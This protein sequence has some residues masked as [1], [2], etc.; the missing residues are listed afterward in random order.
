MNLHFGLCTA[1]FSAGLLSF[2]SPCILPLLPLYFGYFSSEGE[3]SRSALA[4]RVKKTLAF[5]AGVS[6]VFFIMGVGAGLA[7]AVFQSRF[8]VLFCGAAIV[9]MGIHQTGLV[10]I[11]VLNRTR[12]FSSPVV[13]GRGLLG[14]FA[15]GFFFSFGWTPC[16]GP[17]LAMVLGISLQQGD[18]FSGGLLLLFYVAGF[19]IPFLLLAVG[20]QVLLKKLRGL[21]PYLDRI[22]IA[23]GVLVVAMGIWMIA[24]QIQAP[25]QRQVEGNT[26][27]GA[28]VQPSDWAGKPV[29][30]KFWATWCPLCLAGLD[31]FSELAGASAG[32]DDVVIYSVVAPGRHNEMD[33]K[34]FSEWA[35]GQHLSFPVLFDDDGALGRKYGI[36]AYPTSVFLDADQQ[37]AAVHI[38]HMNNDEIQ[39]KL[40]EL[41]KNREVPE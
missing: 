1:V 2:F 25:V 41:S 3:A 39:K 9:L 4:H 36:Q 10:E 8:F 35:A 7:G 26:L 22:R 13:P 23:G 27:S 28:Y 15:L 18:A 17:A 37:V 33:R 40:D 11:P 19:A 38:G 5:V 21:Y 32:R 24:G 6:M 14:A 31:E 20:S 29:Y 16:V 34:T 30:L 12:A